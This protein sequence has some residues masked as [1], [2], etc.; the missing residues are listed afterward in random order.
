[1]NDLPQFAESDVHVVDRLSLEAPHHEAELLVMT[2]GYKAGDEFVIQRRVGIFPLRWDACLMEVYRDGATPSM[3][4]CGFGFTRR[5]A[6]RK[7]RC[8][9]GWRVPAWMRQEGQR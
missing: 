3:V 9:T 5:G 6:L 4:A 7:M 1:M 8:E 2:E